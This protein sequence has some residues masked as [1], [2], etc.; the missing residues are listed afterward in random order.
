MTISE[1]PFE[2]ALKTLK[3]PGV[4]AGVE[5]RIE[6]RVE[7]KVEDGNAV[8]SKGHGSSSSSTKLAGII[9]N[10]NN[11]VPATASTLPVNLLESLGISSTTQEVLTICRHVLVEKKHLCKV[12]SF[13]WGTL[14]VECTPQVAQEIRADSDQIIKVVNEKIKTAEI[15]YSIKPSNTSLVLHALRTKVI[16]S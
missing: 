1:N 2:K 16:S 10:S 8:R 3:T 7:T 13:R 9:Y 12:L 4:E 14:L 15:C 11:P 5:A 6:T